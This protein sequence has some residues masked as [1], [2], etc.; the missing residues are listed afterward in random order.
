MNKVLPR[1]F[2][3][4]AKRII[5]RLL[6][7]V[8]P[9]MKGDFSSAEDAVF[10][11]TINELN[12]ILKTNAKLASKGLGHPLTDEFRARK[13]SDTLFILGSGPSINDL[14]T[15]DIAI[16]NQNDSIGFNFWLAHE[17]VPKFYCFQHT[18]YNNN[19]LYKLFQH[20]SEEYRNVPLIV[21]GSMLSSDPELCERMHRTY[22]SEHEI[23]LL[24]EYPIH[25]KFSGSIDGLIE[26]LV[27]LGLLDFGRMPGFT[28]KLRGTLGL[29]ICFG[30]QMG[31]KRIILCGID[32]RDSTHFFDCD[33]YNDIRK[34]FALPAPGV[35]NIATMESRKYSNNTVSDY[36]AA[37]SRF[38]GERGSCEIFVASKKSALSEV[39][40][41][42][43]R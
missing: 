17:L 37:L 5:K 35:S 40:P 27:N 29:L 38:M 16:I 33:Q 30:Y 24:N 42:W 21:R 7:C 8:Y 6:R 41:F 4:T 36:V 22:F 26:Y 39:V 43:Q 3:R 12:G 15:Q 9:G 18:S 19:A 31:Y 28:P 11:Y 32:M 10:N 2:S 25:S 34:K 1:R 20:R 23:F 14:S 13:K